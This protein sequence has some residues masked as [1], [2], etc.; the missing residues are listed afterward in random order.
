MDKRFFAAISEP[1]IR[2]LVNGADDDRSY[3]A[4]LK[5]IYGREGMTSQSWHPPLIPTW[6]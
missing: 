2:I 4:A 3:F 1:A 6:E 5:N